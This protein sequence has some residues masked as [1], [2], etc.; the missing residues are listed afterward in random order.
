MDVVSH[1]HAVLSLAGPFPS[2]EDSIRLTAKVTEADARVQ[3]LKSEV[4]GRE[5]MNL[6]ESEG[7]RGFV[8]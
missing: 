5:Q 1:F 6:Y 8:L 3:A 4:M 2:Q 7:K